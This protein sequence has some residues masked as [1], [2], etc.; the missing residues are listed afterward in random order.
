MSSTQTLRSRVV[1]LWRSFSLKEDCDPV[2]DQPS[3]RRK[4]EAST[5]PETH[6]S[7]IHRYLNGESNGCTAPEIQHGKSCYDLPSHPV[8]YMAPRVVAAHTGPNQGLTAIVPK[9]SQEAFAPNDSVDFID[10]SPRKKEPTEVAGIP[11]W[12]CPTDFACGL[13]TTLYECNPNTK[14]NTG[15]PI[16]DA[17]GL[18]V[19]ENSAI[20]ALADGVNW[21]EKS[22]LAAQ[23]AV[24]GCVDYLNK[25]LFAGAHN[26]TSTLDVFVCLLRSFEAAHNL[27]LEKDALLTTL[28]AC[29]VC[30]LED[31]RFAVCVCNVG[32]S[33]AYVFSEK[34]GVREITLGSHDIHS[35]RDMRD[36]LG[37][38]GPV[39]GKN[40]ELNNLTVSLT[41]ADEGDMVFLTSDGI[42]D[43]FDP[44][45]GK[46]ALAKKVGSGAE[47]RN[48]EKSSSH[49]GTSASVKRSASH[50]IAS[51]NEKNQ[52]PIVEA[53]QRHA[54]TLLRMEDLLRKG[55]G[56]DEQVP[57]KTSREVCERM[58]EFA[59]RL[60]MAKRRIL[61]DPELYK[62][63]QCTNRER[64]QRVCQKLAL[65][66]G[67]LDHASLCAVR[68]GRHHKTP[69][70]KTT[71]TKRSIADARKA[72]FESP[73][74]SDTRTTE[75]NN[76]SSSSSTTTSSSRLSKTNSNGTA[77]L[78]SKSATPTTTNPT[79]ATSSSRPSTAE[80]KRS[81]PLCSFESM[82]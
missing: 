10:D 79:T 73:V 42:S 36:A 49:R 19:R 34:H 26:V 7:F 47:D 15:E 82:I 28:C 11:S 45:V 18:C 75:K 21:G 41:L 61:E 17:F 35:M 72:F 30:P 65:V 5:S 1:D 70:A 58:V 32:D 6:D 67:K 39:D 51:A 64:R 25:A 48:K 69:S 43:N 9:D 16:A 78:R 22:C 12:Q 33:F 46:F 38:L 57:V 74:T 50:R 2:P 77:E 56:G 40:P 24:H 81:A 59:T 80:S 20:L 63:E 53:H 62:D 60:T 8:A 3:T 54:L 13:A 68:L 4:F 55:V 14:E 37:A 52:L 71:P 44:V 66:P 27:I 31:G 23:C 76:N 29:V